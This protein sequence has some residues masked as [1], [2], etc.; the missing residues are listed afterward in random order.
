[1]IHTYKISGM[2]G[3]VCRQKVQNALQNIEGVESVKVDVKRGEAD[4]SM[5]VNIDSRVFK[6]A[7]KPFPEYRLSEKEVASK[8]YLDE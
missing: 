7:L 2:T 1:M 6:D 3:D 8:N 4:I 5:N